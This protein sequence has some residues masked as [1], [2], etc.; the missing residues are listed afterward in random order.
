MASNFQTL[1]NIYS[2]VRSLSNKDSTTLSDATL[3]AFSNKYFYLLVR[4]LI[5][6]NEEFY[7]EISVASLVANQTEYALPIDDTATT[8]GGGM[9]KILRLEVSHDGSNWYIAKPI[10]LINQSSPI[11]FSSTTGPT[12]ATINQDYST[13]SPEY[14]FFDKSIWLYPI[15]TAASTSGLRI[16]WIKRPDELASSTSIPD[17]PKD[18]LSILQEGILYDVF[19]KFGRTSDA[20]DALNNW[21]VGIAKMKELDQVVNQ[22]QRFNLKTVYKNYK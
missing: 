4:E 12:V 1:A 17:L 19:R 8:F 21:H 9:I 6:L 14:A 5:G 16:F 11:I 3:L 15:P 10:D 13:T 22:E 2:L 20:R 7:G 18:W